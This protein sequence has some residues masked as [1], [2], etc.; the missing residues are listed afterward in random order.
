MRYS[1]QSLQLGNKKFP[2]VPM[3][4]A[5]KNNQHWHEYFGCQCFIEINFLCDI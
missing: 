4:L 3:K 2:N 5:P 1:I